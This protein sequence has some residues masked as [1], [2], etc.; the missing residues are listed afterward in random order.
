[1]VIR[2]VHR[3]AVPVILITGETV[4]TVCIECL[5]PLSADHIEQQLVRALQVA[6]C[7]DQETVDLATLAESGPRCYCTSC[8][9]FL[10]ELIESM[11][12]P[13]HKTSSPSAVVPIIVRV[14]TGEL[15]RSIRRALE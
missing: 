1:M 13:I 8:D 10:G 9:E 7:E 5:E 12:R 11:T 3:Q 4:A 6:Y 14:E 2:C 15:R